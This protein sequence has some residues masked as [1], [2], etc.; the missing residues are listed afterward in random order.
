MK[1]KSLMDSNPYL[2]D[3]A[4]HDALLRQ[5]VISSSAI[6]GVSKA[7]AERALAS[8]SNSTNVTTS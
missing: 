7:V 8:V 5:S 3:P 1:K 6:E 2:K 4:T